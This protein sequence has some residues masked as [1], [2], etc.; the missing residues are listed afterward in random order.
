[1]ARIR[2][3]QFVD[4]D[5]EAPLANITGDNAQV[6]LEES[7]L[8]ETIQE[9][10]GQANPRV[11]VVPIGNMSTDR[12]ILF[13]NI[14]TG[15]PVGKKD[16]WG[17]IEEI[18]PLGE[19]EERNIKTFV[20]ASNVNKRYAGITLEHMR[21]E[22]TEQERI[23]VIFE[24]MRYLM[25]PDETIERMLTFDIEEEPERTV[26]DD[27][28]LYLDHHAKWLYLRG[29]DQKLSTEE[30]N[31]AKAFFDDIRAKHEEDMKELEKKWSNRMTRRRK[32]GYRSMWNSNSNSNSGG[33]NIVERYEDDMDPF[34]YAPVEEEITGDMSVRE[35]ERWLRTVFFKKAPLE[36]TNM[37]LN[38][39]FNENRNMN[40]KRGNK[41]RVIYVNGKNN[42]NNGTRK[43]TKE[44]NKKSKKNKNNNGSA[45]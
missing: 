16:K 11:L 3:I 31:E 34:Q 43:K 44:N 32:Y 33:R 10:G 35:Y 18:Y 14:L 24:T 20:N 15:V 40:R 26:E 13:K 45:W 21:D 17:Y 30:Y 41:G 29:M 36:I 2:E 23:N 7:D 8:I 28:D 25:I 6:L 22:V 1:M 39:L 12:Q 5:T 42:N 4:L 27:I 19:K 9:V 37:H 38:T